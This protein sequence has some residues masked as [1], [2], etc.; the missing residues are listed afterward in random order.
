VLRRPCLPLLLLSVLTSAAPAAFAADWQQPTPD[1]LKMTVDPASPN[2]EAVYLYRE[3]TA[4]DK[5]HVESVYVRL[6]I[7]RE[8]GK[9]YG[10]VEIGFGGAFNAATDIQGRT[11][12]SDGTMIPFT[13]KPYEKLLAKTTTVQYKAKVFS[14]PDVE[15]GSILEYRYKLRYDD[16]YV[17]SPYWTISQPLYVH[18]AHYHF[19][20]SDRLIVS[21]IDGGSVTSALAYS[22]RLP[23]GVKVTQTRGTYDLELA[24]IPALPQEDYA[25]PMDAFAYR[26]RFYYTAINSSEEFWKRYGKSWAHNID[27]FATPSPAIQHA[28]QELTQGAT[29]EDQKL[30]RLYDAVMKLDNTN[31]SREHSEQENRAEGIKRIKS[32]DDIWSLRRGSSDE[33][34]EL[35]L[36][37]ARAA[38]IHAYPM[39]VVNRNR[40][41]FDVNYLS[42]NQLDDLIV[43]AMVDGKERMFDPGERYATYGQLAW[44]HSGVNGLRELE[45]GRTAVAT[46]TDGGY[47]DNSVTRSAA[48]TLA[49]DG[50]LSGSATIV[51]TGAEAMRWRQKALEGDAELLKKEFDEEMAR[52]LS[53]GAIVHLH[54]FLGLDTPE[55]NLLAQLE[56]SGNLG[57][58]TGRRVLVPLAL[59][60]GGAHPFTSSRR[61]HPVDLR[62]PYMEQD[63]ITLHLPASLHPESMPAA[64]KLGVPQMA[65][66]SSSTKA[67]AQSITFVRVMAMANDLYAA[68]EYSKLKGFLD[69][70]GTRDRELAVLQAAAPGSGQ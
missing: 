7:L 43:I 14:M 2:A 6:K 42:G 11:I 45:G 68:D 21:D 64:A 26:V 30:N 69:D 62:F 29:T 22:Q 50:T 28:A 48:L 19:V 63:Q 39:A 66:Y 60:S 51:Y 31:F 65:A 52:E 1:E 24:N 27:H 9:R 8:E 20:P 61:E 46:T 18:K 55:T 32:A 38:G 70:V 56:V 17:I 33:M 16:N 15:V 34:A 59:F 4:D 13:G 47:K 37:L 54:H 12:H 3:Q 58:S 41:L 23:A 25:P 5:L 10:D 53:P 40:G 49:E 36:S 35:F 44:I 57:T 67:D